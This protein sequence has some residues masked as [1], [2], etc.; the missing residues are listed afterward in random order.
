VP[1]G[2]WDAAR[3]LGFDFLKAVRLVILPQALRIALPPTV[4][5]MVQVVKGTS[6]ASIIGFTEL[7][8]A[9]TQI[10]T[11]T[12]EPI[13]VFGTVSL[14]YFSI[15][16]PLSLLSRHLERQLNVGHVRIQAM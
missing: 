8:R 7:A 15:C 3:S 11:I 12:F 6:L 9:G 14:I 1:P 10:N 13:L 4:G 5:Y 16:W 2:Q